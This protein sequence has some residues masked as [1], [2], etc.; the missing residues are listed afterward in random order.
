MVYLTVSTDYGKVAEIAQIPGVDVLF[1]GPFDLGNN[2]GHPILDGAM[3]NEL[4]EAIAKVL[5][6]A[7]ESGKRAGIYC[8]SGEQARE[9][10]DQGFHMVRLF[11]YQNLGSSANGRT[12]LFCYRHGCHPS[13]LYVR[14]ERC[15]GQRGPCGIQCRERG[16]IETDWPV[17][18]MK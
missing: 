9:Y 3:H 8:T 17:W 12:D 16:S 5:Q 13:I 7:K 10:A 4:K 18:P 14:F 1:V 6:T 2:I 11:A 15:E